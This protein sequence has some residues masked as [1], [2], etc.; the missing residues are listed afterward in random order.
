MSDDM[1][2]NP[3]KIYTVSTAGR[4]LSVS[5]STLRDLERRGKIACTRTP[6]GQRRFR[7]AELLRVREESIS[8]STKN[9]STVSTATT[10][11]DAKLRHTW[12]GSWVARAQRELPADAPA[13]TRLQLDADLERALRPLGP[14]SPAGDV[15][16][17]VKSLIDRARR[18][19]EEAREVAERRER[20]G[21]LL[22]DALAHLRRRI[23]ALPTR[24]AGAAGSLERRHIRAILR[25]DL[26]AQLQKRFTGDE[27]W[28]QARDLADEVLA[29]W[30]V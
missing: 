2:I 5:P 23:D 7:G 8:V 16:R 28:D 9:P 13:E 15:E 20:K 12:L 6:G 21:Q 17:L 3:E 19:M 24:V 30:Y 27:D 11:A 4:L 1:K 26:R 25:D 10:D 22:E 14:D 29:A 18:Q